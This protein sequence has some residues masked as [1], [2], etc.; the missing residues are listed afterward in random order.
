MSVALQESIRKFQTQNGLTPSGSLDVDTQIALRKKA[1][2]AG[3]GGSASATA[4]VPSAAEPTAA[5]SEPAAAGS[6]AEEL[7][8]PAAS[9]PAAPLA[10]VPLPTSEAGKP[11]Q[12][13]LVPLTLKTP[14]PQLTR[15]PAPTPEPAAPL[16]SYAALYA[17]TPL[18]N[19]PVKVQ[20]ETL[21]LGQRRLA[22]GGFYRGAIDGKPGD[23]TEEALYRFQAAEGLPSSGRM[24]M[25][26]L[27]ELKLIGRQPL[28]GDRTGGASDGGKIYQGRV[29]NPRGAEGGAARGVALD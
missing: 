19:A 21:L 28:F 7:A 13:T 22:D 10:K 25:D 3:A 26:T 6:A 2:T 29:V 12:Q 27:R 1:A 8:A 23:V 16:R 18:E 24:D 17:R 9:V 14:N 11:A 4:S 20:R 15:K 5:S